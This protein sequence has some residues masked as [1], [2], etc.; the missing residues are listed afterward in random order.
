[1]L[2]LVFSVS[3]IGQACLYVFICKFRKVGKDFIMRHP[4]GQPSQN[5]KNRNP[6]VPDTGFA[7]SF[8]WVSFNYNSVINHA[9]CI[10]YKY[11]K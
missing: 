1:M 10:L 9:C 8:V 4:G 6:R 2:K 3:S 5:I 11:S 7:K